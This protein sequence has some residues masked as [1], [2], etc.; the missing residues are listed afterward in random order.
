[1]LHSYFVYP[2]DIVVFGEIPDVGGTV[3][4]DVEMVVC[5]CPDTGG[6]GEVAIYDVYLVGVKGGV[7][8]IILP[9]VAESLPS[10]FLVTASYHTSHLPHAGME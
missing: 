10:F 7:T 3:H 8:E 2:M 9:S 5:Q 1:M 4:H 6:V